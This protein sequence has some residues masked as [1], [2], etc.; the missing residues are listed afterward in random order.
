MVNVLSTYVNGVIFSQIKGYIFDTKIFDDLNGRNF[1][2]QDTFV[3]FLQ[4]PGRLVDGS[5]NIKEQ[6]NSMR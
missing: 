6:E 3:I 1:L 4:G 2:G 5:H